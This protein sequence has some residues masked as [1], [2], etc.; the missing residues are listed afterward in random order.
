MR[1][2]LRL[3]IEHII[4]NLLLNSIVAADKIRRFFRRQPPRSFWDL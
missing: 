4:Q 1:A 3:H 2:T